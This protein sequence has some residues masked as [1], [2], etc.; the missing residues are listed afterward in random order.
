MLCNLSTP[1]VFHYERF[2]M[3]QNLERKTRQHDRDLVNLLIDIKLNEKEETHRT[4]S[5]TKV[6]VTWIVPICVTVTLSPLGNWR[7]VDIELVILVNKVME[8]MIWYVAPVLR[9][10]VSLSKAVL[11]VGL[12]ANIECCILKHMESWKRSQEIPEKAL[13]LMAK[14]AECILSLEP[15]EKTWEFNM[16]INCWHCKFK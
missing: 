8:W 13:G 6:D 3:K 14:L 2:G 11:F 12:T 10:Q 7:K 5:R 9:T 4:F 15:D 16:D 1:I